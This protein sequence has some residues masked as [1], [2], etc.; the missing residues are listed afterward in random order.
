MY[1]S[2]PSP[3]LGSLCELMVYRLDGPFID[4]VSG[5]QGL[6]TQPGVL[7]SKDSDTMDTSLHGDTQECIRIEENLM[8][9]QGWW[10][11]E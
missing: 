4:S 6:T 10:F 7:E 1:R 9:I 2:A 3:N 5:P 11:S 8:V